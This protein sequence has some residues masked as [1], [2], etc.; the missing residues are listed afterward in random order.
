MKISAF[1]LLL[2]LVFPF[3]ARAQSTNNS[4]TASSF[5]RFEGAIA[6]L[7]VVMYLARSPRSIGGSYFYTNTQ[8]PIGLWQ[9]RSE[10]DAPLTPDSLIMNEFVSGDTAT[11]IFYLHFTNPSTLEGHWAGHGKTLAVELKE[12]YPAGTTRM[13]PYWKVDSLVMK[14][15]AKHNHRSSVSSTYDVL[16]PSASVTQEKRDIIYRSI[17]KLIGCKS[18]T[19][20]NSIRSCIKDLARADNDSAKASLV[21]ST[22]DM[23]D[24]DLDNESFLLQW[25]TSTTVSVRYDEADLLVLDDDVS[26]FAGGAHGS[27]YKTVDVIDL[28]SGKEL[29]L[30]D[31]TTADSV[32]LERL[33][34]PALRKGFG[35]TPKQKL[36]EVLFEDYL[37]ANNNFYVTQK[38]LGF[39]YNPYEVASWAQGV[40]EVYI[41]FSALKGKLTPWFTKRMGL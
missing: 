5:K 24:S 7:Q 11:N 16:L 28:A 26:S 27:F 31:I 19:D 6:K 3:E 30:K 34:E 32:T 14:L 4:P 41:P 18:A 1:A 15:G 33:L 23:Q 2:V 35:L 25:Y 13:D 21:E 39:V 22:T 29:A 36:T 8:Q 10:E 38:G 40:I 9:L 12:A 17:G 37:A 20:D